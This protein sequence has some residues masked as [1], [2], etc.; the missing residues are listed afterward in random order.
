MHEVCVAYSSRSIAIA[1]ISLGHAEHVGP[2]LSY[3]KESFIFPVCS[4]RVDMHVSWRGRGRLDRVLGDVG[5]AGVAA[6]EDL[7]RLWR[8]KCDFACR[9]GGRRGRWYGGVAAGIDILACGCRSGD[10]AMHVVLAD[11]RSDGSLSEGLHNPQ[12]CLLH[13]NNYNCHLT[14]V[15]RPASQEHAATRYLFRTRVYFQDDHSGVTLNLLT[16]PHDFSPVPLTAAQCK[17]YLLSSE[18]CH[19]VL[20]PYTEQMSCQ[21]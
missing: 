17:K 16:E 6:W 5:A 18:D 10:S 20:P 15:W 7:V 4:P 11:S 1:P 12:L 19:Y 2:R 9:V 14:V 21:H 3:R 8:C 13:H